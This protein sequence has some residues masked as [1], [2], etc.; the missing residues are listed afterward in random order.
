MALFLKKV[1]AIQFKLSDKDKERIKNREAV[2]FEN[3][4]VKQVGP[5]QYLAILQQGENL[6]RI[7]ESQWLVRHPDGMWQI[8]WPDRF[9]ELFIKGPD[10]DSIA[11]GRDPFSVKS[12][13]QPDIIL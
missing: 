6:H 7:Y 4:Q 2:Y 8:I 5:N 3:S 9:G 10:A 1:D 13:N 11:I 12:Y